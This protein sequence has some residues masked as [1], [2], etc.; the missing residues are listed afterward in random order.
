EP[1]VLP[2]GDLDG[3][4]VEGMGDADAVRG[5]LVVIALGGQPDA[6]IR[7]ELSGLQDGGGEVGGRRPHDEFA[8]L[9][10]GELHAD[11]VR[12]APP[13]G[14]HRG[15]GSAEEREKRHGGD[16]GAGGVKS[17]QPVHCGWLSSSLEPHTGESCWSSPLAKVTDDSATTR[18]TTVA[19]SPP[20]WSSWA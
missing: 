15:R 2:V 10:A 20:C 9:D 11:G 8:G 19:S 4:Q 5:M 12:E 13:G 1:L 16:E 14:H 18:P 7:A 17:V 6:A 3:P